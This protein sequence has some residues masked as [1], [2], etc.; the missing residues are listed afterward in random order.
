MSTSI[1]LIITTFI[2]VMVI[3]SSVLNKRFNIT[4]TRWYVITCFY[5]LI[6]TLLVIYSHHN[7][8]SP[9]QQVGVVPGLILIGLFILNP[10]IYWYARKKL[11][12]PTDLIERNNSQNFIKLDYRYL[13]SKTCEIMFQQTCII[14]LVLLLEK[15]GLSLIQIMVS[16]SLLFS[17]AHFPLLLT[18]QHSWAL[19]YIIF[20]ALSGFIFPPLILKLPSGFIYSFIV[21]W[22]FYTLAGV[23]FWIYFNRQVRKHGASLYS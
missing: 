22:L 10:L 8:F 21:H 12:H 3:F 15:A 14:I 13:A 6:A 17:L 11:E 2:I 7:Y 20:S 4:H 23:G 16:F 1:I 19:Y 5:F 18:G 9:L